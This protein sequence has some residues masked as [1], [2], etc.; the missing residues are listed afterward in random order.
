MVLY[1]SV[2]CETRLFELNSNRM[3]YLADFVN[4]Q[5]EIKESGINYFFLCSLRRHVA[6]LTFYLILVV[7]DDFFI[8][9]EPRR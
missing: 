3:L 4:A 2:L 6:F 5:V 9:F 8:L 1:W 7:R